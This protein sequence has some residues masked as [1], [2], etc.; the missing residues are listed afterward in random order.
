MYGYGEKE[1]EKK[2]FKTT[3]ENATRNVNKRS[4]KGG[5]WHKLWVTLRLV[6]WPL[7]DLGTDDGDER[8]GDGELRSQEADK[9]HVG[10]LYGR[11]HTVT[12]N[13]QSQASTVTQRQ[14]PATVAGDALYS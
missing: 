12:I 9:K 5:F 7:T 1:F 11:P 8:N 10:R 4:R 3:V 14:V 2:G 6:V 13:S